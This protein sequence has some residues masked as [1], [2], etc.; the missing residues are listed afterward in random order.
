MA[1]RMVDSKVVW[2]DGKMEH[3]TVV[4][5][6]APTDDLLDEMLA[7]LLVVALAD[8]MV[9]MPVATMVDFEDCKWAELLA[10]LTGNV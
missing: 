9:L 5:K 6:V 1:S 7:F 3:A 4:L 8:G 10:V 2:W